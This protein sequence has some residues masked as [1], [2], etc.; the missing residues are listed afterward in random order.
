MS[1]RRDLLTHLF[2]LLDE[3]QIPW[4]VLRNY[5]SLFDDS[6]SDVDLL[7][8]PARVA[9][10]IECCI[11]AAKLADQSLVQRT[12]FVNHSL[13]FWNRA[14]CF[15]RIDI[16]TEKRW[17]RFH[18]I[19]AAQVLNSRVRFSNTDG[20]SFFV[21]DIKHEAVGILTQ[22]MWQG[23]L[24][25]RYARRL[26]DIRSQTVDQKQLC[27][28]FQQA[29]GVRENL[30]ARVDDP[31]LVDHLRQAARRDCFLRPHKI[32][33]SI[34]YNLKDITRFLSRKQ[35]PPGLHVK[36]V[37]MPPDTGTNL[38]KRLAILFP[39]KKNLIVDGPASPASR[40]HT[41]FRGGMVVESFPAA[42]RPASLLD[43]GW[44]QP[45]RGFAVVRNDARTHLIHVGTGFM[46]SAQTV[47]EIANFIC[48]MLARLH[49]GKAAPRNGAFAVL[50]GL[51]G[52]GKTTLARNLTESAAQTKRISGVRYHHWLPPINGRFEFPLP[53]PGNQPRK[54]EHAAG[55]VQ[56]FLSAARLARNV[57]RAQ[58]A[59]RFH[60][61]PH[62]KRG[63]LV[64]VDRY[65]YNYHLDPASVRYHGPRWL[66]ALAGNVFPKP[67]VVI[68]LNAPT[69]ILLARKQELSE[70]QILEQSRT[71]SSLTFGN[72]RV[73]DADATEPADVVAGK[74]MDE[75]A[76]VLS[77]RA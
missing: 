54:T 24:S 13:V 57:L 3:R 21:P 59:W 77:Q 18:L 70:E 26:L 43:G 8:E 44:P 16:D 60:L 66:L 72:T 30:L 65:F 50:L 9:A 22:A 73:I 34:R 15:T 67:D 55:L 32:G 12:R 48:N 68:R 14:E 5:H 41:L 4:C 11:E 23:K 17:R 39:L 69:E 37:G 35:S 40:R 31:G 51:D 20:T 49:E 45:D 71:L 58:L 56:A 36:L 28:V 46:S 42:D 76:H 33:L 29:F 25:D 63:Y 75:L 6:S 19:A 2:R 47:D 38:A 10:V 27:V 7:T 1:T 64:I 62:C 52:S 74:V 61:K 53:E